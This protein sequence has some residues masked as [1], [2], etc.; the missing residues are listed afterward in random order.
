MSSH[1]PIVCCL[2]SESS[3]THLT[4]VTVAAGVNLHVLFNTTF[5]RKPLLTFVPR[6]HLVYSLYEKKKKHYRFR[7]QQN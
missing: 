3:S 2:A 7:Y 1:V 4:V 6:E 5:G